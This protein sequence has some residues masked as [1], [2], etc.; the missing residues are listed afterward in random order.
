MYSIKTFIEHS[1]PS[2]TG[3]HI[4]ILT[5][6]LMSQ[7]LDIKRGLITFDNLQVFMSLAMETEMTMRQSF[8]I[9]ER[10]TDE[11]HCLMHK[12][13]LSKAEEYAAGKCRYENFYM[14]AELN[15]SDAITC[16]MGF[17]LKHFT[18]IIQIAENPIHYSKHK[19]L[20]WLL[21]EKFTDLYN[22][23][24]LLWGL[25]CDLRDNPENIYK[26]WTR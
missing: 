18:S 6:Q 24:A 16:L 25:M 2:S 8:N 12:V 26:K 11:I 4:R 23:T 14:S 9:C 19:D 17:M 3:S 10:T 15:D 21:N 5:R 22:Y 13:L 1:N 20:D 7:W